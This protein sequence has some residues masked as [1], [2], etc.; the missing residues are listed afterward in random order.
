VIVACRRAGSVLDMP[1]RAVLDHREAS[2]MPVGSPRVRQAQPRSVPRLSIT[3][4]LPGVMALS[5]VPLEIGR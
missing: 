4:P 1:E 5:T 3:P 2:G